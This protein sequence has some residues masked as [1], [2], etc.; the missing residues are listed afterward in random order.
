MHLSR[1]YHSKNQNMM[2]IENSQIDY[3]GTNVA[4]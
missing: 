3:N 4:W 2:F 1:F